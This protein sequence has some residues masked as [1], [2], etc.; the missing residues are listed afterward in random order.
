MDKSGQ[1]QQWVKN[2]EVLLEPYIKQDFEE[3]Q[4]YLIKGII[5]IFTLFHTVSRVVQ[6]WSISVMCKLL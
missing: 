3:E 6:K 1:K 4:K 2:G 5:Y